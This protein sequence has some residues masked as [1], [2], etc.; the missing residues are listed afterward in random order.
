MVRVNSVREL[1]RNS[2]ND[3]CEDK[4][5][6]SP[7]RVGEPSKK[8]GAGA[9]PGELLAS[10][11]CAVLQAADTVDLIVGLIERVHAQRLEA[12]GALAE[13]QDFEIPPPDRRRFLEERYRD[14]WHVYQAC[15]PTTIREA[16]PR[17]TG[18]DFAA[19][20]RAL[21]ALAWHL[22][23]PSFR[24]QRA[25]RPSLLSPPAEVLGDE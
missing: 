7:S 10:Q 25:C 20:E 16:F 18:H 2:V 13:E 1:A 24:D 9:D 17:L 11:I 19:F 21:E 23:P 4:K 8:Q 3:P 6:G 22:A 12:E 14:G 15:F 5:K